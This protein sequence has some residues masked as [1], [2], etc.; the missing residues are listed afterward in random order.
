MSEDSLP[1]RPTLRTSEAPE[2]VERPLHV[3]VKYVEESELMW[4]GEAAKYFSLPKEFCV[5]EGAYSSKES[6]G[7]STG[8]WLMNA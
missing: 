3:P 5:M 4:L 1:S 8:E 2:P 6:E 7:V